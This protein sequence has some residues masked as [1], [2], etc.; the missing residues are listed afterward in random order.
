MSDPVESWRRV[1]GR[2]G[3]RYGAIKED[4]WA[5]PTPCEQWTVRDLVDHVTTVQLLMSQLVGATTEEGADWPA[6][7][8]GMA[9][10]LAKP[11][12][13]EGTSVHPRLGD[14][15]KVNG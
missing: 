5:N 4:Q 10:A 7:R 6:V 8:D 15:P 12:A 3:T 13:L 11:D 14:G 9:A 2:F 1:A